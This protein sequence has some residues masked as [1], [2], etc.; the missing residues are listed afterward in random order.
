MCAWLFLYGLL[1]IVVLGEPTEEVA[2][3]INTSPHGIAMQNALRR[4]G[5]TDEWYS[6]MLFLSRPTLPL[7]LPP[8]S[9]KTSLLQE[10]SK[11]TAE[12]EL[13][14]TE[15]LGAGTAGGTASAG[16]AA[17]PT[18]VLPAAPMVATPLRPEPD[19][20]VP[21]PPSPFALFPPA[22]AYAYN[23]YARAP[24]GY[25]PSYRAPIYAPGAGAPVMGGDPTAGAT[26]PTDYFAAQAVQDASKDVERVY[27]GG[28]DN[29]LWF[30]SPSQSGSLAY[31]PG[32]VAAAPEGPTAEP[33][34]FTSG[35]NPPN[36]WPSFLQR[37]VVSPKTGA[38]AGAATA[39]TEEAAAAAS[40]SSTDT[41]ADTEDD[42]QRHTAE[43][44]RMRQQYRRP[45]MPEKRFFR[46]DT[47][48]D[49]PKNFGKTKSGSKVA[50]ETLKSPHV[51]DGCNFE[52]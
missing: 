6:T 51:C 29:P 21:S 20:W 22:N 2:S 19:S 23:P 47:V 14:A 31:F 45:R 46:P 35:T 52:D 42:K 15:G 39:F 33:I 24:Y 49:A 17:N 8:S 13:Q 34:P 48:G 3:P 5:L 38:G 40:S 44:M 43:Q 16:G 30:P 1:A 4:L 18:Y 10:D 7:E 27:A 11:L 41:D 36:T 25:S 37:R 50:L 9:S 28:S 26:D 32:I 12:E